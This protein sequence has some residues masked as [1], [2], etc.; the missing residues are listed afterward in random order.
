MPP[1][2][3]IENFA[4]I[5]SQNPAKM[6]RFWAAQKAYPHYPQL[7][8]PPKVDGKT[9]ENQGFSTMY[10]SYAQC[11]PLFWAFGKVWCRIAFFSQNVKK[12][13]QEHYTTD[14]RKKKHVQQKVAG[15]ERAVRAGKMKN[16]GMKMLRVGERRGGGTLPAG[17]YTSSPPP[18]ELPLKGKPLGTL[19]SKRL[20]FAGMVLSIARRMKCSRRSG[21]LFPARGCYQ[22]AG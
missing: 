18:A 7:R 2:A 14:G 15:N 5:A 9:K 22:L 13:T 4:R 20:P 21:V 8:N 17:S 6:E 1:N 19:T 10:T 3:G 16:G 12:H 11:Y